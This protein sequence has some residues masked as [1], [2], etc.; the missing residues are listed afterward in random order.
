VSENAQLLVS[1]PNVRNAL[2]IQD[3]VSGYW[4]YRRAGLLDITHIR[5]FTLNDMHRMFYQTGFRVVRTGATQCAGSA[6]IV[7]DNQHGI[8]PKQIELGSASITVQ[9]PEDLDNLCALQH[10][11]T[12]QPANYEQLSSRERALIHAP[13]PPT[14]AYSPD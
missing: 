10:L 3:L 5:F 13:H 9:S 8:F 7:K 14:L 11:F 2:L 4:R 12:L 6:Q 1:I